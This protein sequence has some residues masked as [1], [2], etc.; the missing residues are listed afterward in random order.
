MGRGRPGRAQGLP[1]DLED[2]FKDYPYEEL[3]RRI[4]AIRKDAARVKRA[5]I[6]AADYLKQPGVKLDTDQGLSCGPS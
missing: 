3:G 4:E 6:D 1:R 2:G 5:E